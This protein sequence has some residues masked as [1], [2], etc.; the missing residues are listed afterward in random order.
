[1]GREE[2]RTLSR[3][4]LTRA[5]NLYIRIL[6]GL[7]YRDTT[8]G[9]RIFR[10]EVLAGIPWE[11]LVSRGPSLLQEML[12]IIHRAGWTLAESPI[13]FRDRVLG[14][15]DPEPA[16]PHEQPPD[17]SRVPQTLWPELLVRESPVNRFRR[18]GQIVFWVL[19]LVFVFHVVLA[20]KA[21]LVADEAYYWTWSLHPAL[22]YFDHPPMIAWIL[23][24]ST[25]LFGTNRWGI[26]FPSLLIS[27]LI[28]V[29][30]Y[31]M[32]KE[33]LRD[34]WA[35]LWA[36]FLVSATLLFSAGSFLITPD[37]IVI[38]FF[39]LTLLSFWRAIDRNS[40]REML[41]SGLW[42]GLGLLSKYTMVLLGPLL[43]LFLL[44]DP[45][46]RSWFRRPSL[47][48]AGAL[49]L[50]LFTPVILWNSQQAWGS[51]RFQWHHGMQA[52]QM[53]PLDGLCDY[54]GG[55]LGVMT[56][57]VYL[58]LLG[59]GV[60]AGIRL[61]RTPSRPLLFLWV[62]SYPILLFFAYSSLKAK[63]EANWP[64]EGYLGAFLV[65]GALLAEWER[66]PLFLPDR[67]GR[68]RPWGSSRTFWW[69]SSFSGPFCPSTPT[70]IRRAAWRASGRRTGKIRA[71]AESLPEDQRPSAWLVDGYSNASLLKFR[72]Y[73][74]TP[75]YEIHP[76][77]PFRT[78]V[79]S[80]KEARSLVGKPVLLIQNG[81]GGGFY[82]E[83]GD[84]YGTMR[85]LGTL[86][87]PRRGARD[88]T[89]ILEQD[90]Y[91]IPAFRDGLS[92][93]PP[94]PLKMF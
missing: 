85:F 62:T 25:H 42:F 13:T 71:L 60:V 65:A 31:R 43:V 28:G 32:A 84:R 54:L 47:W 72:E 68:G 38:L 70:W 83:L 66:G 2:G 57:I 1:G 75:V 61:F 19:G 35:G 87:I 18:P 3:V 22:S 33:M 48:G 81:P 56:P 27:V 55:Q 50:L 30:L 74:R 11:D 67:P 49:A 80:E 40:G 37:S 79:L 6:L 44:L 90:V 53:A 93:E 77:R 92:R 34:R 10:R 20:L 58:I 52:H 14:T 89:P 36:V 46:G 23:W 59:A 39:L 9:F 12:V 73:G 15:S 5:G 88:Q 91:L 17:R 29:F 41:L 7:P 21:G 94:P 8:S 78:T 26:R 86:H 82:R 64:V 76:K 45:R 63:V 4:L 16:D 51:F 69:G 24:L